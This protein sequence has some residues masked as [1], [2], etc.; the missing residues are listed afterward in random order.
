MWSAIMIVAVLTLKVVTV[1]L[2]RTSGP[3]AGH[4]RERAANRTQAV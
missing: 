1:V 4:P 2:R 3:L